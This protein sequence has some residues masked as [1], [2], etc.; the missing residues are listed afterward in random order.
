MV[1]NHK[2][3]F[4]MGENPYFRRDAKFCV[5]FCAEKDAKF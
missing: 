3:H 1:G 2:V 4:E 5:F